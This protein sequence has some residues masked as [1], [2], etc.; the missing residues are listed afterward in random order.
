ML[1]QQGLREFR[2]LPRLQEN[3]CPRAQCQSTKL[4]PDV[5]GV[6]NPTPTA[7]QEGFNWKAEAGDPVLPAARLLPRGW[8]WARSCL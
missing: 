4:H 1:L 7:P 2:E 6:T 8:G 5:R 3:T